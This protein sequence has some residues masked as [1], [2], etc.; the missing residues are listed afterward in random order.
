VFCDKNVFRHVYRSFSPAYIV[1]EMRHLVRDFRVRDIAFIDSTFTPDRK[2]VQEIVSAIRE[3]GLDVTWTC[4]AR[5][6]VLD[7]DLLKKMKDAGCWR[8]RLGIESGNDEV[9]KFI[10]KGLTRAQV[11]KTAELAYELDLEPKGFFMIG[12]L[13]DT[14]ETIEETIAFACSLPL[15][16][17]TVQMNTPLRNTPQ[18]RMLRDYGTLVTED[19]FRYT[20]W[21][22][23][24]VPRGLSRSEL[25]VYY[26]RFYLAFY[27]RPVV[28]FRHVKSIR[29]FSDVVKYLRGLGILFYFLKSWL[30]ERLRS[31]KP[32]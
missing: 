7:R 28:W 11:R 2:R 16:D 21:E 27:L 10:K 29:S 26:A 24:F 1:R 13:T 17:V 6:D 25:G 4:S 23:V 14:R 8:V 5:A 12:H 18:F 3:A 19:E 20:F 32:A 9:L 30:R 31:E 15:K 22:P